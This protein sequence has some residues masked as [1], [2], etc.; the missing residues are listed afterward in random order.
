M[1]GGNNGINK[2]L[3]P[4]FLSLFSGRNEQSIVPGVMSMLKCPVR[5]WWEDGV[6]GPCN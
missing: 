2:A 1:V 4:N 6:E 5:E 3:L